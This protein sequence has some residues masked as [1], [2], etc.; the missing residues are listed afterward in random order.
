[1]EV[2]FFLKKPEF[3]GLIDKAISS[4]ESEC[5]EL[6]NLEFYNVVAQV[7]NLKKKCEYDV[8]D[9]PLSRCGSEVHEQKAREA[10]NALTKTSQLVLCRNCHLKKVYWRREKEVSELQKN[11]AEWICRLMIEALIKI[12]LQGVLLSRA[13]QLSHPLLKQISNPP[14]ALEETIFPRGHGLSFGPECNKMLVLVE[15]WCANGNCRKTI[16]TLNERVLWLFL[17][18]R[19]V[20]KQYKFDL[21]KLMT[22]CCNEAYGRGFKEVLDLMRFHK[23]TVERLMI[24]VLS[25]SQ[26]WI[27]FRMHYLQLE[28]F[29]EVCGR[30]AMTVLEHL[31]DCLRYLKDSRTVKILTQMQTVLKHMAASAKTLRLAFHLVTCK[32]GKKDCRGYKANSKAA[33]TIRELD[34]YLDGVML[35]GAAIEKVA[36]AHHEASEAERLFQKIRFDG[37][38]C[39]AQTHGIPEDLDLPYEEEFWLLNSNPEWNASYYMQQPGWIV[40]DRLQN[41]VVPYVVQLVQVT[42]S[43]VKAFCGEVANVKPAWKKATFRKL[44]KGYERVDKLLVCLGFAKDESQR[45]AEITR[46]L[47]KH[48]HDDHRCYYH[49]MRYGV[50]PQLRRCV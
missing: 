48:F 25:G 5:D 28:E 30:P 26:D 45:K 24:Q 44:E 3:K 1:M 32:C 11:V 31:D 12:A 4:N 9:T 16:P 35:V 18:I 15:D 34:R 42:R 43:I 2:E 21:K 6:L 8:E 36:S 14:V 47:E 27:L 41:C 29:S 38:A 17:Q 20:Q 13:N 46:R 10:E 33:Y 49:A 23:P 19:D 7:Q 39:H 37:L 22:D 50:I 40:E